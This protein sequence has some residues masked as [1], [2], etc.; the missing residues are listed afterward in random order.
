MSGPRWFASAEMWAY[1]LLLSLE[2]P[3]S[4]HTLAFSCLAWY[5]RMT[6]ISVSVARTTTF[7]PGVAFTSILRWCTSLV[8]AS[9][10]E[11]IHTRVPHCVRHHFLIPYILKT[12]LLMCS[13]N[14]RSFYDKCRFSCSD[15][16]WTSS[17]YRK[18]KVN[19]L[20]KA[21]KIGLHLEG[22]GSL[23]ENTGFVD[24]DSPVEKYVC[25]LY[26]Q[27]AL[28]SVNEARLKIFLQKY[29]PTDPDSP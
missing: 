3:R 10:C 27:G 4:I 8:S 26:G 29:K 2:C 18:G 23:G 17:F 14:R 22:L 9:T 15:R 11:H 19:P 24:G 5:K 6:M 1:L 25:S 21:E 13:N 20:K 28:S 12:M 7:C 16:M